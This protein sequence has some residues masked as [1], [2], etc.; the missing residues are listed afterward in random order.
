LTS[1]N[2]QFFAGAIEQLGGLRHLPPHDA[3]LFANALRGVVEHHLQI[4]N[5]GFQ[6]AERLAEIVN[7][8][9]QNLFRTSGSAHVAS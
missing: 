4:E 5:A 9:V 3:H 1:E 2:A 7:Q 8:A 6:V